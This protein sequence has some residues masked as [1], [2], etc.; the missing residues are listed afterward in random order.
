MGCIYNQPL[1][2][3][4]KEQAINLLGRVYTRL[5]GQAKELQNKGSK[6]EDDF[7]KAAKLVRDCTW[8]YFG[9]PI[10][11]QPKGDITNFFNKK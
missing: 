2:F 7:L 1:N 6:K 4:K 9:V 10:A 8:K 3:E 5:I 11:R